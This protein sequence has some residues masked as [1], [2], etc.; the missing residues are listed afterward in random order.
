MS[1]CNPN[2]TPSFILQEQHDTKRYQCKVCGLTFK[3]RLYLQTVHMRIHHPALTEVSIDIPVI[4]LYTISRN[5]DNELHD[6]SL[7]NIGRF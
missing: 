7:Q 2:K 3:R 6:V 4:R 5:D 1:F